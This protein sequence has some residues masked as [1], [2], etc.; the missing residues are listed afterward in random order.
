M[1]IHALYV[2][3]YPPTHLSDWVACRRRWEID[4]ALF[5]VRWRAVRFRWIYKVVRCVLSFPVRHEK[6]PSHDIS[7]LESVQSHPAR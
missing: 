2:R 1:Q 7:T 4:I 3:E 6:D 5:R